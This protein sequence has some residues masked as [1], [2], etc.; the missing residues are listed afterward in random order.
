MESI[1]ARNP[2]IFLFMEYAIFIQT[3]S[4]YEGGDR[5]PWMIV[6]RD[7]CAASLQSL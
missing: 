6:F 2:I 7:F 3:F 5:V 1:I 4:E